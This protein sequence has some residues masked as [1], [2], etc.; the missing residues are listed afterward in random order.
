[1][2]SSDHF[3][4]FRVK[5]NTL[6]LSGGGM[7]EG[8]SFLHSS[9]P[10]GLPASDAAI[11]QAWSVVLW[12]DLLFTF[13]GPIECQS[14]AHVRY[15]LR[16]STPGGSGANSVMMLLRRSCMHFI[17]KTHKSYYSISTTI[18]LRKICSFTI[19]TS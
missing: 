9:M 1:M 11:G 8:R 5:G 7:M 12:S 17:H 4:P 10:C 6:V 2:V 18:L 14:S 13:L 3:I 16:L 19:H 15:T